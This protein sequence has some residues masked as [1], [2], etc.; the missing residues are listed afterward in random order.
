MPPRSSG[1][2]I[3]RAPGPALADRLRRT[4]C[5]SRSP[6]QYRP[7]QRRDILRRWLSA[8]LGGNCGTTG[9]PHRVSPALHHGAHRL[10]GHPMG[11]VGKVLAARCPGSDDSDRPS[12]CL[13]NP[14]RQGAGTRPGAGLGHDPAGTASVRRSRDIS[15]AGVARLVSGPRFAAGRREPRHGTSALAVAGFD[16]SPELNR[17]STSS[18]ATSLRQ[19]V[20]RCTDR[21][22]LGDRKRLPPRRGCVDLRRLSADRL[23]RVR[24][25]RAGVNRDAEEAE[26]GRGGA[27]QFDTHDRPARPYGHEI[28]PPLVAARADAPGR[29]NPNASLWD[30]AQSPPPV[31]FDR[32]PAH[33]GQRRAHIAVSGGRLFPPRQMHNQVI[34]LNEDPRHRSNPPSQPELWRPLGTARAPPLVAREAEAGRTPA[35]PGRTGRGDRPKPSQQT[36][37]GRDRVKRLMSGTALTGIA[38]HRVRRR[39][40]LCLATFHVHPEYPAFIPPTTTQAAS[41]RPASHLW[42]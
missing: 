32:H 21:V 15:M 2:L 1:G 42:P 28:H 17:A 40:N 41:R 22:L 13:L 5:A 16:G 8:L 30:T 3:P 6:N 11:A 9:R 35:R 37:D 36:A 7:I 20:L 10:G 19:P 33:R 38:D 26:G 27:P 23:C 14:R 31:G 18:S 29:W 4:V 12:H 39:A 34:A 24:G 25:V